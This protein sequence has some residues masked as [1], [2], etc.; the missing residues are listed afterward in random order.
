[1]DELVIPVHSAK[2]SIRAWSMVIHS[3]GSNFLPT[4]VCKRGDRQLR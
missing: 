1:M 2:A 4:R 3:V